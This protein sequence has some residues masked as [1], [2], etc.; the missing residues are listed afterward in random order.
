MWSPLCPIL[1]Y[2]IPQFWAKLA[3]RTAHHTLLESRHPKATK[4]PY[5]VL[6]PKGS[7]KIVSPHGLL[8]FFLSSSTFRANVR[9]SPSPCS[10]LFAFHL[11][12]PRNTNVDKKSSPV[13]IFVNLYSTLFCGSN[14]VFSSTWFYFM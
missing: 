1:V 13:F 4:N 14:Y 10:F 11:E 6:S 3:I 7:Q 8:K 2:K 5:Y 12:W 9:S